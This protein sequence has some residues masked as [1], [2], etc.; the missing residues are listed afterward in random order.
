MKKL[1]SIVV[2]AVALTACGSGSNDAKKDTVVTPTVVVDPNAKAAADTTDHAH[3]A[4]T[5]K[6]H[7]NHGKD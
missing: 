2:I 5:T 3:S 7:H 6:D 4:D 1:F